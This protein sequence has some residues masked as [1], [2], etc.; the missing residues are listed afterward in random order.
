[1]MARMRPT[2]IARVQAAYYLVAGLWPLVSIRSFE[3]V[4]GRRRDHWV[5]RSNGLLI[6]AVGAAVGLYSLTPR[7]SRRV[8][9]VG[10]VFPLA[11]AAA[12]VA[13][14][15]PATRKRAYLADAALSLATAGAWWRS[16]RLESRHR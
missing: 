15:W 6:A 12:D 5:T 13:F 9:L 1:M 16:S 4:A 3:A 8:R 2:R 10:M 7:L 11:L 14:A